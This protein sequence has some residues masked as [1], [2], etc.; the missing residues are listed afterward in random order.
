MGKERKWLKLIELLC[1]AIKR[2]AQAVADYSN[3]IESLLKIPNRKREADVIDDL[4]IDN[5]MHLQSLVAELAEIFFDVKGE[6]KNGVD[7]GNAI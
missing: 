2:E 6:D 1:E 3:A 4:R 5:V 7:K